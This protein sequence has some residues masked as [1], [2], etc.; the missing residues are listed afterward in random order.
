MKFDE[1]ALLGCCASR[2]WATA[3]AKRTFATREALLAA[4]EEAWFSL[5]PSDRLEAFAG[6][7]KIGDRAAAGSASE[8]QSGAREASEET[9]RVLEAANRRY[10]RKF[11]FIFIVCA[12]GKSAEE[13]LDILKS[14]LENGPDVEMEN[15]A[16]EQNKITRIRLER[17]L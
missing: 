1:A 8:E 3:M 16:V 14:R 15:A 9:R 17:I 10:E 4:A 5:G 13:M 2:A 7:P 11:G 12:T 6:H